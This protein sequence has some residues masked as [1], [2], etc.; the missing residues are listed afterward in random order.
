MTPHLDLHGLRPELLAQLDTNYAL[1]HELGRGGM[2]VVY[3]A[4]D[5][6]LGRQVAIKVLQLG[7]GDD[8]EKAHLLERF[9]QESR[10]VAQLNHPHIVTLYDVGQCDQEAYMVMEYASGKALSELGARQ[11]PLPPA[12]VASLGRQ[13]AQALEY[14]HEA[15]VIHRDIKPANIL[16]NAKG[17][18]KLMDFGIARMQQSEVR[19]TQA[20]MVMGSLLYASPEQV[21]NAS[22]VN[23]RT[24]I[25]SLGVTLYEMLTG[26]SPYQESE[27]HVGGLLLNILSEQAVPPIRSLRPDVPESLCQIIET[28]LAKRPEQRMSAAEM[29]HALSQ[30]GLPGTAPWQDVLNRPSSPNTTRFGETSQ[31]RRTQL[32]VS[33]LSELAQQHAWIL[34]LTGSWQTTPLRDPRVSRLLDGL[35]EQPLVGAAPSG[36]L[37]LDTRWLIFICAGWICGGVDVQQPGNRF[38]A[39]PPEVKSASFRV[40]PSDQLLT[41]LLLANLTAGQGEEL[42]KNLD[43]ALVNLLPLLDSLSTGDEC[44]TGYVVAKTSDNLIYAGF[45]QGRQL[46]ST[47]VNPQDPSLTQQTGHDLRKLMQQTDMVLSVYRCQAT[48]AGPSL[49]RQLSCCKAHVAYDNAEG[50]KPQDLVNLGSEELPIHLI[51]EAKQNTHLRL[52]LPAQEPP[53]LAG[54]ALDLA[55]QIKASLPWQLA[56]WYLHSYF[57]LLHSSG[58][59]LSLKYLYTWIAAADTLE[60]AVDLPGADGTPRAFDLIARGQIPGEPNRK[61]LHLARIGSGEESEV[62][63]F[64]EDCLSVKKHLIK[65]GD[66][67]GALYLA[68]SPYSTES[69]K[70]FYART[71]EPRK[72]LGLG[73][74][75]KL[76]RYKGFVRMGLNRGFHLNLLEHHATE[77]HFSVIAPSLQ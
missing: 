69:L 46:F 23:D 33:A 54:Q 27:E 29:V 36:V 67:G 3:L 75:D 20:G 68:T 44:L 55:G 73:S 74:L 70:L 37:V 14:A 71:V 11:Q 42:Q 45:D 77:P 5:R 16:L 40:A 12:L 58:N 57:Y 49:Q 31:L 13:M 9:R 51:R 66:V 38:P 61:L 8:H 18:A 19:L 62:L 7:S 28:A 43:A 63:A 15:G 47:A 53:E 22:A 56:H 59:A 65:S 24:D 48:L 21:Q 39:L 2:G 32:N 72:G 10:A 1:Q 26:R 30:L 4:E 35:Q 34:N 17:V 52:E 25:Y 41:P 6:R 50:T 76:T 64:L 60:F